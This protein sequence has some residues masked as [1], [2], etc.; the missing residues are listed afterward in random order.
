M[1]RRGGGWNNKDALLGKYKKKLAKFVEIP[2][3]ARTAN[4]SE[5]EKHVKKTARNYLAPAPSRGS[6]TRKGDGR[7]LTPHLRS[8]GGRPAASGESS[9]CTTGEKTAQV[10]LQ[11]LIFLMPVN[12]RYGGIL[13]IE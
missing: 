1:S 4:E 7:D 6:R 5:L 2:A 3:E 8:D 11:N 12:E 9:V 13:C 10:P